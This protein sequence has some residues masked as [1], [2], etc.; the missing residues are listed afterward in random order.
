[1][2]QS[3]PQ[4]S[5]QEPR[6]KPSA[7]SEL[8]DLVSQ[9][10]TLTNQVAHQVGTQQM[11]ADA[12]STTTL[13]DE[14]D[15]ELSRLDGGDSSPPTDG[16]LA[17]GTRAVQGGLECGKVVQLG[18]PRARPPT[19]T[20]RAEDVPGA[21]TRD[22]VPKSHTPPSPERIHSPAPAID[23]SAAGPGIIGRLICAAFDAID[24]PFRWCGAGGRYVLGW[25]AFAIFFAAALIF[26]LSLPQ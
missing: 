8:D 21:D 7:E 1:M 10:S 15:A 19:P 22:P 16:A 26:V 5:P 25:V 17:C 18:K 24:W 20:P 4:P 6:K 2:A 9:V 11:G 23:P 14:L 3:S 12:A 13:D